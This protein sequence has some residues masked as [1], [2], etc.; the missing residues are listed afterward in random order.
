MLWN[1]EC[2]EFLQVLDVAGYALE[3]RSEEGVQRHPV[4]VGALLQAL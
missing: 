1:G 4:A 2:T 3:G